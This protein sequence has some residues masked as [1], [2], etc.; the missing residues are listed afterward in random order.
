MNQEAKELKAFLDA[1]NKDP[2]DEPLRKVFSDWLEDHDEP[3]LA[4]EHRQF[5]AKK[6][7]AKKRLHEIADRYANGDYDGLIRGISKDRE[8]CFGSEEFRYEIDREQLWD[9]IETVTDETYSAEHRGN[10]SFSC[11]C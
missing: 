2:L 9:D 11:S 5:S 7:M 6:F 10:T 4:D 8:Y 1:I 3:E